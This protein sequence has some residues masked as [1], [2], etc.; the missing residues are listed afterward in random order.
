MLYF[1]N[2]LT[3]AMLLFLVS[4]GLNI[5]FGILGIVNFAHGALFIL[6]AYATLSVIKLTGNFWIGLVVAPLLVAFIAGILEYIFIRRVY[7]RHETYSILITFAFALVLEDLCM[8]VWGSEVKS[9]SIPQEISGVI[10]IFGSLFPV[11]SLVIIIVG[12]TIAFSIW[13]LFYKTKAGKILRAVSSDRLMANCIGLNVPLLFTATFMMGAWLAG[14]GGVLGTLRFSFTPGTAH[15]YLV[16][17]FAVVVIGGLGSFAGAFFGSLIVGFFY[18]LGVLVISEL[19]MSF[20]FM[21]LLIVLII[22]P[23]GLF[24]KMKEARQHPLATESAMLEDTDI[25]I[26]KVRL[27]RIGM[28]AGLV[29]I[30]LL[31]IA[32]LWANRYW[33]VFLTYIFIM[34]VFATSFN[35]LLGYSG[36][37]SLGQAAVFSTGAYVSS[38]LILKFSISWLLAL[39]A[40]L[41]ASTIVAFIMGVFSIKRREIYF[42]MITVAFAQMLYT[43]IYKWKTLTGGDDGLAGIPFAKI[44]LFGSTFN[45]NTPSKYFHL[46]LVVFLISMG[47]LRLII[48]SP[49]GQILKG[50]RENPT[51]VEFIGLNPQNYKLIAFVIAGFFGGLAGILFAPYAGTV[52][53]DIAHWSTST[54]PLF[55]TIA[56]G[57]GQFLG[58]AVGTAIYMILKNVITSLTQHWMLVLGSILVFIVMAVPGGITGFLKA[59]MTLLSNPKEGSLGSGRREGK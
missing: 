16:Y 15:E 22:R 56:G 41:F 18:I 49:F 50:I 32:P 33:L 17:S 34:A 11:S 39:S 48:K 44:T 8:T 2:G 7:D 40:G 51:R 25:L 31:A 55:M 4:A 21:L 19:A 42:A 20:V 52:A 14:I 54:E 45:F 28:T 27:N 35:L 29:I 36:M 13:L 26:G 3:F 9:V 38:I 23:H 58:P 30:I 24:G 53:P 1:L 5:I 47:L 57:L 12:L 6:G 46:T 59:K 37:L 43:V 10:N